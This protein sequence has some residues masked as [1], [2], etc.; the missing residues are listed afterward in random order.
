MTTKRQLCG[1]RRMTE[2]RRSSIGFGQ[3]SSS[4]GEVRELAAG[5]VR[6]LTQLGR[7]VGFLFEDTLELVWVHL[8]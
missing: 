6:T 7:S 4:V 5:I 3:T 1:T 2:N 8:S